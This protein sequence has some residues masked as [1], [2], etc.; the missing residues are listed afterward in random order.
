MTQQ[1]RGKQEQASDQENSGFHDE[2]L[3]RRRGVIKACRNVPPKMTD[4]KLN[5]EQ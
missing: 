5:I 2:R 3:H 1:E 4:A